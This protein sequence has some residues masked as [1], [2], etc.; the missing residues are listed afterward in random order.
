M[1]P[2]FGL[3]VMVWHYSAQIVGMTPWRHSNWRAQTE[4]CY[5]ANGTKHSISHK[6]SSSLQTAQRC[7]LLAEAQQ[8]QA[9]Q[10]KSVRV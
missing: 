1:Y 4:R 5:T 7:M 8:E 3:V 10:Q 9:F 2:K 6:P